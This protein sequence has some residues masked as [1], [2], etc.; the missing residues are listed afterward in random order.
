MTIEQ[1]VEIPE[2]GILHLDIALPPPY[3]TGAARF[4]FTIT[5]ADEPETESSGVLTAD[6][7]ED[8]LEPQPSP[9]LPRESGLLGSPLDA[10][11]MW[12]DRDISLSSIREKAW[13]RR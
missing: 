8:S 2:N 10:F 13:K 7:N 12:K 11:G 6:V 3:P 4:A 5:P 9:P 1:T